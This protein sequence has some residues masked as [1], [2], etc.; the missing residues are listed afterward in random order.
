[1]SRRFITSNL[2]DFTVLLFLTILSRHQSDG[3]LTNCSY[4]NS[5]LCGDIC[6]E[7]Q[8]L[9]NCGGFTFKE[10]RRYYQR[11]G[12]NYKI[13]ILSYCCTPPSAKCTK[14][15]NG[16]DCP[17]GEVYDIDS[18]NP[19][20]FRCYNDYY[21]S[22]HLG[23]YTHFTCPGKCVRWVDLCQ[24]VSF[25]EGDLE[26]C[27]DGARAPGNHP[28]RKYLVE[29]DNAYDVLDRSDE[30]I[31]QTVKSAAINYSAL[32]I[33]SY[34]A[35]GDQGV[36]CDGECL[37][38][39]EWCRERDPPRYCQDS[40]V[41]TADARL[42]SNHTLWRDISCNFTF[43][44]PGFYKVFNHGERCSG[45][46]QECYWPYPSDDSFARDAELTNTCKDLSDRVFELGKPCQKTPGNI[47]YDSCD[48]PGQ[49]CTSCSN[50]NYFNCSGSNFCIHPSLVC[51][52]HPQ[53]QDGEDEQ[54]DICRTSYEEKNLISK[55]A[56]FR[57][58]SIMYPVVTTYATA[59]DDFPECVDKEDETLCSD[60]AILNKVLL[61]TVIFIAILYLTLRLG[62]FFFQFCKKDDEK[63]NLDLM[64]GK[65]LEDNIL[66][67][68]SK[69]H[70]NDEI[71]ERLNSFL[72]H[73]IFTKKTDETIVMCR[74]LYSIESKIHENDKAE[75]FCCLHK[76][77]D[78]LIMETVVNSQFKGLTKKCTDKLESCCKRR[79][80]TKS[81]DYSIAHEWMSVIINTTVRLVKIEFQYLD[82]L[83]DFFLACSLFLIVGG[84]KAI[85][86]FPTNF[87][88]VVVL[89]LL[90]SVIGPVFF[91][92]LHL[93]VHN[94]FLIFPKATH[95][96]RAIWKKVLMISICCLLS[97]FNPIFLVNAYESAKERTRVMA[98]Y[99]DRKVI[100]QMRHARA[101]KDQWVSFIQIELGEYK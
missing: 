74:E 26:V 91:A 69:D 25:C 34:N 95:K 67:K 73:I 79:W 8:E 47:C 62:S 10:S 30:I 9:C 54:M 88:I 63:F 53:C 24:G 75:I 49:G 82:I 86:E 81:Y 15:E 99:M 55:Y 90:S 87:S 46:N 27:R 59:C 42:C 68:Y 17:D 37:P 20:Y 19:C 11:N 50:H 85:I 12:G 89:C 93:V 6:L 60:D 4:V 78:P 94:P 18:E 48:A 32:A 57:C 14:T 64:K 44:I 80:I 45:T 97:I 28:S 23:F 58:Q 22:E 35:Q 43:S 61:A 39:G 38:G 65:G 92:T 71:I 33:C 29:N 52:G 84:T 66:E 16:A 100:L 13:P 2:S 56:T 72:L 51:D 70:D 1:M 21:Q 77:M 31:L 40:G 36:L 101:I 98:R 7:S 3:L 5:T 76:N 96:N 83:K 41:Y